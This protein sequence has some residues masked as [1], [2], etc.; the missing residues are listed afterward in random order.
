M[1]LYKK[2][3]LYFKLDRQWD[4]Y[5]GAAM[6]LV[7][8]YTESIESCAF[9][10]D[11]HT[12]SSAVQGKSIRLWKTDACEPLSIFPC[13][14]SVMGCSF[15]ALGKKLTAGDSGD[16][17]YIFEWIGRKVKPI[18]V[19]APEKRQHFVVRCPAC[20][21]E[22]LV[23]QDQLGREMTCPAPGCGLKLKLNLFVIN[24]S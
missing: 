3:H 15:R 19:T 14:G 6:A 11:G 21:R 23:K 20:Q 18:I 9:S 8:G 1:S 17:V 24:K 5:S 13:I 2:Y 10:Q 12:L 7:G 16:N 22:H 4:T